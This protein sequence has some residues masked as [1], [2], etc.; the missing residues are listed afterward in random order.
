M[1]GWVR[2][3]LPALLLLLLLLGLMAPPSTAGSIGGLGQV[4]YGVSIQ[5]GF[6]TCAAPSE[7]TMQTWW[8]NSPYW[9]VGIY[10]GGANRGCSQANLNSTWTTNV[11][12]Q[13]WSYYLIWV[14]PQVPA[15]CT[16]R[17]YSSYMTYDTTTAKNEGA[18]E[19]DKAVNAAYNLG[20]TGLNMYYY[21]L[22]G[23]TPDSP[24]DLTQ[25]RAVAKAF[26]D[27]WVE[28]LH[29]QF[30][31]KGG[32]YGSTCNTYMGDF[33]TIT[34]KPDTVWFAHW[35]GKPS[36]W[37]TLASCLPDT[38][39]T[40]DKR[41]HQYLGDVTE[42]WGNI[43]MN[44]DTDCSD[45]LVTPEGHSTTDAACTAPRGSAA[46]SSMAFSSASDGWVLTGDGLFTT[47]DAG[48]SWAEA[49]PTNLDASE[50]QGAFFLDKAHGWAASFG[51]SGDRPALIVH[52]TA[53]GGKSWKESAVPVSPLSAGPVSLNFVDPL[54]GWAVVREESSSNFRFG[55]LFRTTDGGAT[56]TELSI[57]IGESVRFLNATTGWVAGGP[58]GDQLYVTHDAGSTWE[59]VKV[60]EGAL[61][62]HLPVFQNE[63]E[64]LLPV[65]NAGP[66]G[67]VAFYETKDGG[68]T[69]T[70]APRAM[71]LSK[72]SALTNLSFTSPE[73]G[74]ALRQQSACTGFKTGCRITTDLVRTT[75]GGRSWTAM[76]LPKR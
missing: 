74:W 13:G 48:S 45:G 68:A 57:P 5:K 19:A 38:A 69:W 17:T 75:D 18:A 58:A 46:P 10:I 34:N 16:A 73:I 42:T 3:R 55:Q 37:E 51:V 60:A 35:N 43:T 36:V 61:T 53:D 30:G 14:G 33:N 72:G 54:H 2:R 41:M 21:D 8:T 22:E 66:E 26:I 39:F 44:I 40:G 15:R 6:D 12:N 25:C 56:W 31:E 62:N 70:L 49:T 23:Y 32:V 29:T 65:T 67:G 9:D 24:S 1:H 11:H 63:R 4:R 7:S 64:G 59:P 47:A 27:G 52:Q 71:G 20:F 76:P 28:R 50:L